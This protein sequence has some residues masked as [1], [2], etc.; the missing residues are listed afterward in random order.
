[1]KI[2]LFF[3]TFNPI[4]V[5]H[6]IIANHLAQHPDIDQVWLVVTPHNPHKE[7]STLLADYLRLDM[8]RDAIYDSPQLKAC[9]IEFHLAKPNYTISTLTHLQEKYP[10]DEFSLLLGADN[11]RSF[12]KWYNWEQ[13]LTHHKLY[14]YPRIAEAETELNLSNELSQHPN[15]ELVKD[16]PILGISASFVRSQLAA[17]KDCSFLLTEPVAKFIADRRLYQK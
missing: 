14:V 11:L 6:L 9:D 15:I 8:V 4:H 1:M 2:G 3:G 12:Q 13:I 10:N 5:G 17:G 16:V 7:K